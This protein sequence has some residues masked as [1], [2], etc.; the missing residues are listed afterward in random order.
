[1]DGTI[2]NVQFAS[3][4]DRPIASNVSWHE[5]NELE[6]IERKYI[7]KSNKYLPPSSLNFPCSILVQSELSQCSVEKNCMNQRGIKPSIIKLERR[8]EEWPHMIYI[9]WHRKH[10]K[11]IEKSDKFL[12][13]SH[14]NF[15]CSTLVQG[16][17][18][19]N[20]L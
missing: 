10:R 19:H 15:P 11:K 13:S 6:N 1:M 4:A 16:E 14:F 8:K 9:Q 18:S 12:S 17:L 20:C 5:S 7:E 2:S 3:T